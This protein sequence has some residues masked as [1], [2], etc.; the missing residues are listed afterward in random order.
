MRRKQPLREGQRQRLI[1][2][3][4]GGVVP[5]LAPEQLERW[6][7]PWLEPVVG[8]HRPLELNRPAQLRR[9]PAASAAACA[10]RRRAALRV[11]V[12]QQ[13]HWADRRHPCRGRRAVAPADGGQRIVDGA[14]CGRGANARAMVMAAS[15]GLCV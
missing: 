15:I 10:Y 13:Q 7:Q 8:T 5:E 3:A 9:R 4:R 6:Q 14:R 1:A 11:A 2:I 12:A